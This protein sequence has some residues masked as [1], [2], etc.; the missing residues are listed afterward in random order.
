MSV[1]AEV[2]VA[3]SAV[4]VEVAAALV[5]AVQRLRPEDITSLVFISIRFRS[6]FVRR[7]GSFC[8]E[9]PPQRGQRFDRDSLGT[10]L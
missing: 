4:V 2:A 5:A 7:S 6:H 9:N 8:V 1:P 3:M 10:R